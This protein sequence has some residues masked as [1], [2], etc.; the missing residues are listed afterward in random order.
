MKRLRKGQ[1]ILVEHKSKWTHEHF[2]FTSSQLKAL[3]GMS[4]KETID[5]LRSWFIDMT[6]CTYEQSKKI[7][8]DSGTIEVLLTRKEFVAA[9]KRALANK[10]F[11]KKAKTNVAD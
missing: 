3:E 11:T 4:M 8:R 1:S 5:T 6:G 2:L 9:M 7:I 10:E